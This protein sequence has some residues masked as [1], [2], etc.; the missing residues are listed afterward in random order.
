MPTI[1]R[2][3]ITLAYE[4]R[5]TGSPA[6]VFVHGWTCDRSFFAPQAEY[7]GKRHRVVSIDLRG[8]GQSDKPQGPYPISAYADDIAYLIDTLG[9]GRV[10]AVGHSMGGITVLQLGAAYP[11]KVAG[12]VMVDPAPLAFPPELKAGIEALVGAIEAGDQ[13]PRR[14]FIAERLF[15]PTSD[16]ALVDRVLAVMMAA[17]AHVASAAMRG[18][19]GFEGVKAAARCKVPALHIAATPPL[20]PPHQMSEWLPTVVNGWTVG[21]G[22]F[23]MMEAPEQ[24]NGMIEGFLRHHA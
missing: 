22:H 4:E 10:I 19:L 24:V 13:G 7:F 8:H 9:L 16:K 12:I 18:I 15:L 3:G 23:N 2:D 17:P 11:E 6:F 14:Q 1:T 5:G 20:N 21:A